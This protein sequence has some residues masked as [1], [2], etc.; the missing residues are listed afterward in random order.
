MG[1]VSLGS[2][3]LA[4]ALTAN[5]QHMA[6]AAGMSG[7]ARASFQGRPASGGFQ[8]SIWGGEFRRFHSERPNFI[9]GG[10]PLWWDEPYQSSSAPSQIILM[11]AQAG[12]SESEHSGGPPPTQDP[13]VIELRGDQYV[14]LSP[15]AKE[16]TNAAANSKSLTADRVPTGPQSQASSNLPTIFVFR[17]GHR[18]ESS[19]YSIYDGVIHARSDLWTDGAWSKQI[20]LSALNIVESRKANE[21]RGVRFALPSAPNEVVTRP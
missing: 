10:L 21:E 18:E 8:G 13:L 14:R 9:Y 1:V 7:G 4:F 12:A 16:S 17:D 20:P 6:G 2:L 11:P 3:L 15:T 19:D 5:A